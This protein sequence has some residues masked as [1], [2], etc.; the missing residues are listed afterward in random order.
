MRRLRVLCGHP[1]LGQPS[2][3]RDEFEDAQAYIDAGF[4]E[5]I[6]DRS[7]TVETTERVPAAEMTA[8]RVSPRRTTTTRK[9]AGRD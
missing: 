3:E 5:W 7:S 8:T 2:D 1:N 9:R 4:A 6:V